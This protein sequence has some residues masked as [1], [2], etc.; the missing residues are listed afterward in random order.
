[1]LLAPRG[2][3]EPYG[4]FLRISTKQSLERLRDL[5][6][7]IRGLIWTTWQR[8]TS[9]NFVPFGSATAIRR[10]SSSGTKLALFSL[11]WATEVRFTMWPTTLPEHDGMLNTYSSKRG[12]SDWFSPMKLVS[13]RPSSL[14]ANRLWETFL[15]MIQKHEEEERSKTVGHWIWYGVQKEAPRSRILRIL[16]QECS[17]SFGVALIMSHHGTRILCTS[18]LTWYPGTASRHSRVASDLQM[19]A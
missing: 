5:P 17:E 1:M 9:I 18:R 6:P 2:L 13:A 15:E 8:K 16:W 3:S 11:H 14:E 10:K 7:Q 19:N 4:T 12:F